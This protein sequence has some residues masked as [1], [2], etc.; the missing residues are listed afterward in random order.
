MKVLQETHDYK[1]NFFSYK[2]YPRII[3]YHF[4]SFL[5][6]TLSRFKPPFCL[7]NFECPT[8]FGSRFKLPQDQ[9]RSNAR[10]FTDKEFNS[11]IIN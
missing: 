10:N 5:N 8:N 1:R 7:R 2:K 11:N 3:F 4:L 6:G 9:Y